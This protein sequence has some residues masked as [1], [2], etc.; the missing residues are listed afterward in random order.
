MLNQT[1]STM[2]R[3]APRSAS[4]RSDISDVDADQQLAESELNKLQRQYRI[5]EGDRN[6]YNIE[7]QDLIR[8]Q[9]A[10]IK[11]L[12][13]EKT[14]L[15][16][17]L[18]L[19]DSQTNQSKDG[20]N[21]D[22]LNRLLEERDNYMQM[23]KEEKDKQAQLDSKISKKEKEIR[24]QHK[25]MG[26]VHASQQHTQKTL[27]AVRVKENRL[28]QAN[29]K[30]NTMLTENAS[31]R[32]EIDS[33]RVERTRFEN[34]RKRLDKEKSDLRQE[35]GEVIDQS[36]QA[37]DS[38]DEAQAKMILLKE[39]ADKDM[40]QHQQE[41]KELQRI[42]DHDKKLREFMNV[43]GKEREEDD[44]LKT[45][46]QKKE[47]EAA[48]KRRRERQEDSIEAY[49]AAF[50]RISEITKEEDL[51]VLVNKFVETEDRNFALFNF[52]NE[53]NNEMELLSD[54]IGEVREEMHKFE[55][56]GSDMEAERR[57]ILKDL[58][59]GQVNATKTADDHDSKIKSVNKI[60]HQLKDGVNSLFGK[61]N[62][63]SSAITSMLGSAAGVTDDTIMQ[64]LGLVEQRTN[65]L[66]TVSIYHDTKNA[67]QVESKIPGLLGKGPV[68]A[69][70]Q[71]Q[72]LPPSTGDEYDSDQGSEMSDEDNRPLTQNELK[73]KIM[74]GVLK[75]EEAAKKK[76]FQYDLSGAKELK[77]KQ[78]MPDKKR[79][80][81]L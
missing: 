76:G 18:N 47:I 26:G 39:K 13:S 50:E 27:K 59:E 75:R 7:S 36:T 32:E 62:C 58:E 12:E 70:A 57:A 66:L 21:V 63:D 35:I 69:P 46:R 78:A 22:K 15:M 56:Q 25:H 38:R 73:Q 9:L 34:I 81:K 77:Q 8:K 80:G 71:L 68:Q 79:G 43:K 24:E 14:E 51:N 23:V 52:V 17:D 11:T 54:Q 55:Q 60:L 3:G 61:T 10:E 4:R 30:F 40:G 67:E 29:A 48:D 20:G 16:K 28:D 37:Y 41:M 31:L 42:I 2:P 49:E 64:Y 72:I 45:W 19:S 1:T 74:K 44:Y 65:E 5:M 53:K 33:F 6:A